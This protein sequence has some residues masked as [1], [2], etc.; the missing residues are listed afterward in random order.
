LL[1]NHPKGLTAMNTIETPLALGPLSPSQLIHPNQRRSSQRAFSL[2]EGLI[3]MG[4]LS[5]IGL[6]V[7]IS[8]SFSLLS[9]HE[10]KAELEAARS[11]GQILEILRGTSYDSLIFVENGNLAMEPLGKFQQTVLADIQDRLYREDFSV[12]LTI[13]SHLGRTQSKVL[14]LTIASIGVDPMTKIED[15]PTGKILVKQ[16]TIVTK[17]GLN[18]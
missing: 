18:P 14:Y 7:G 10:A 6:L 17:K 11:A 16:S 5:S 4:V 12:Y 1:D 15:T 3:A 2:L 8:F 9:Q 13:R